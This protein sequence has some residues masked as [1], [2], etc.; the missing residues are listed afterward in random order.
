MCKHIDAA[1][2][3][4]KESDV[5]IIGSDCCGYVDASL[6]CHQCEEILE[7]RRR[8]TM[9]LRHY[10]YGRAIQNELTPVEEL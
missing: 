2:K 9:D 1:L 4:L 10:E 5:A 6:A 8:N 3:L 7:L